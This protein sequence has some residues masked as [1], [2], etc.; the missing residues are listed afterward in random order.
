MFTID[1]SMT[2]S[3]SETAFLRSSLTNPD[4]YVYPFT[5]GLKINFDDQKKAISV[6]VDT[7]GRTYTLSAR[8]EIIVSA[9]AIGSPQLLQVSGVGPAQLLESLDVPVVADLVGVGENLQDHVTFGVSQGVNAV[10][11]SSLSDPA[12]A[13]EQTRLFNDVESPAGILTSPGSDL[14]AWEKLPDGAR[15]ALSNRTR[16]IL[17]RDYPSDWPEVEYIAFSTY[18]SDNFFPLAADP[19]DG[20]AYAALA[21][22]LCTPRSRGSIRISSADTRDAPRIDPAFLTDD[23]DVEVAVAGFRRAREFWA[24]SALDEFRVGEEAYPGAAEVPTEDDAAIAASI[25]RSF[26]S[27]F[28]PACTCAMGKADDPAAVVDARARVYGVRGLRVVDA[29]AFPLLP[30]GHPQS[31][32]C[33]STSLPPVFLIGRMRTDMPL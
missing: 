17:D 25:R 1:T 15:G 21:V 3:S 33:K 9:G 19:M 5:T 31:T 14:L 7:A 29:S 18:L 10:T 23:A 24:A 13:A 12:F 16:A 30:P 20:T 2:R 6:L 11:A 27:I 22:V 8:K 26:T 32:V 28:H 4:F